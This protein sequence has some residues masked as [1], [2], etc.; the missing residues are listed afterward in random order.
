MKFRIYF[1]FNISILIFLYNSS[2]TSILS[3]SRKIFSISN[4]VPPCQV[5]VSTK[6]EYLFILKFSI[7]FLNYQN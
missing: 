1:Y 3:T 6:I 7:F 2:E 4:V 5:L